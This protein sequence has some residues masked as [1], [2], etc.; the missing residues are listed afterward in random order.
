MPLG[1]VEKSLFSSSGIGVPVL[2]V[3]YLSQNSPTPRRS[4]S[5]DNTFTLEPGWIHVLQ[6]KVTIPVKGSGVKIPLSISFA[7]RT[8]LIEGKDHS[9]THWPDVRP[10]TSF[11]LTT[12][13]RLLIAA[14][15]SPCCRAGCVRRRHFRFV[16]NQPEC[17]TGSTAIPARG[18]R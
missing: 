16:Q 4:R 15:G 14:L 9:R 3:A 17:F 13:K 7:N 8:E 11:G 2:G 10:W 1:S 18:A 5:P 12:M 6:G